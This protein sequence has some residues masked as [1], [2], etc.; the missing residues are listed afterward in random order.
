MSTSTNVKVAKNFMGN[1]GTLMEIKI[2]NNGTNNHYNYCYD[3]KKLSCYPSEEEIILSSHCSFV[4]E[5][6]NRGDLFDYVRLTC[7][8]FN[9]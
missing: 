7:E 3:V 8:G 5:Q 9:M 1:N 6:I 2:K 4:V